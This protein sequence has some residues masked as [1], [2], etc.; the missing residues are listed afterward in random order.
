[1]PKGA[2]ISV[3]GLTF[4]YWVDKYNLLRISTVEGNASGAF[5]QTGLL[6]LGFVII[7]KP[8]GSIIFDKHLRGHDIVFICVGLA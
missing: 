7:M 6:L 3:G 1:M 5:I 8:I 4:Y 2:V